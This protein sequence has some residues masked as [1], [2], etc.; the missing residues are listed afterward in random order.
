MHEF[1]PVGAVT[2]TTYFWQLFGACRRRTPR[3]RSNRRVASERARSRKSPNIESQSGLGSAGSSPRNHGSRGGRQKK[4]VPSRFVA[5]SRRRRDVARR[6]FTST[7]VAVVSHISDGQMH[8]LGPFLELPRRPAIPF[9]E[10]LG[11]RILIRVFSGPS[12]EHSR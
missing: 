3:A 9:L 7:D 2:L 8:K 6:D 10:G 4:I 5:V 1:V 12:M 11:P